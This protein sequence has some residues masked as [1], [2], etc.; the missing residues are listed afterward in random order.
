[1]ST[2][3]SSAWSYSNRLQLETFNLFRS[4]YLVY[5]DLHGLSQHGAISA[6]DWTVTFLVDTYTTWARRKKDKCFKLK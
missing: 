3:E 6:I 1:M 4:L 5:R 2:K